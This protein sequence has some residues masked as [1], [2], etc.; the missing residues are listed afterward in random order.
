MGTKKKRKYTRWYRGS[1]YRLAIDK[2][3]L[4]VGSWPLF[5]NGLVGSHQYIYLLLLYVCIK[6]A[7]YHLYQI[8][9]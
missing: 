3:K 7:E 6:K 1:S 5:N 2:K 8:Y 4:D 9:K